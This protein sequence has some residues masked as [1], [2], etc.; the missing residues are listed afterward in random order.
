MMKYFKYL[1]YLKC[2]FKKCRIFPDW[3]KLPLGNMHII[4]ARYNVA[5][6]NL[7]I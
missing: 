3:V 2:S 4:L 6:N 7:E 1:N 5:S